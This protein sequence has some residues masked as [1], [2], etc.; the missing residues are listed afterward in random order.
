[1][2]SL[3]G[4]GFESLQLHP[5]E[6]EKGSTH[7]GGLQID[8]PLFCKRKTN[9]TIRKTKNYEENHHDCYASLRHGISIGAAD[10]F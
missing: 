5:K 8:V 7:K 10:G 2:V 1:M 9:A 4:R 6:P 3:F